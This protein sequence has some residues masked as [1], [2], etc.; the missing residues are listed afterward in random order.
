MWQC[1]E[2]WAPGFMHVCAEGGE[3]MMLHYSTNI[4]VAIRR[5]EANKG[6][7]QGGD[8]EDGRRANKDKKCW[9]QIFKHCQQIRW[10]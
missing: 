6:T 5:Q 9:F 8:E 3:L 4:Q 10:R 7:I 1:L 2:W